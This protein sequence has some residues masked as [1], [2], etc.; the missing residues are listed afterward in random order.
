MTVKA[1]LKP[2]MKVEVVRL[3]TFR[4][5]KDLFAADIASVDRVLRYAAPSH[6]PDVPMWIEGVLEHRGSVIPVVDLRRRIDLPPADQSIT[7]DT[8]ILVLTTAEGW[9][10]AIVDAVVE[11]AVIP[12]T[13]MSAP[14]PLFRG[15]VSRFLRGVA[16]VRE[17]LVV[18]L[19]MEQVLTSADRLTFEG[20]L[21]A[22]VP[23]VVETPAAGRRG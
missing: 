22:A 6:V 16:T 21:D 8:R 11:V 5:G 4:L 2:G 12:A 9:I 19:E 10:G 23:R 15:L 7:A 17:R 18:V 13:A 3:V 1:G 20:A 14:P